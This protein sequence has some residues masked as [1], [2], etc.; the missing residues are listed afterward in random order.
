MENEIKEIEEKIVE[1]PYKDYVNFDEVIPLQI[2]K[3]IT[4]K[5]YKDNMDQD[6]KFVEKNENSKKI[7]QNKKLEKNI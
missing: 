6:I 7:V 2:R 3:E 1:K 5:A 4:T